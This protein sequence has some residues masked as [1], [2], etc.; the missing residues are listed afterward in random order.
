MIFE[1]SNILDISIIITLVGIAITY[2]GRII[3]KA[4]KDLC[5]DITAEILEGIIFLIYYFIFPTLIIYLLIYYF[6]LKI[7]FYPALFI[8]IEG[9]FIYFLT[10]QTNF[11]EINF[12]YKKVNFLIV[13]LSLFFNYTLFIN[14]ENI[15]FLIISIIFTFLIITLSA[16]IYSKGEGQISKDI[17][18]SNKIIIL[19]NK[20]VL[21]GKIIK[22]G[23]DFISFFDS[24]KKKHIIINKSHILKL[25]HK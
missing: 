21:I 1:I 8:I 14:D 11:E 7:N 18:G 22:L 23:N 20:E 9:I 5:S 12:N 24:K 15:V 25:E 4:R 17:Q 10:L 19:S 6:P 13:T 2:F 3:I 16:A